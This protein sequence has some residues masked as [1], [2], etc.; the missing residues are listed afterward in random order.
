LKTKGRIESKKDPHFYKPLTKF[1]NSVKTYLATDVKV[2]LHLHMY[3]QKMFLVKNLEYVY[4]RF[5]K[6]K[7][8]NIR[9]GAPYT[10][11]KLNVIL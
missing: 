11:D 1:L 5:S 3:R 4:W 10:D 8:N 7:L 2:N 6:K 9:K